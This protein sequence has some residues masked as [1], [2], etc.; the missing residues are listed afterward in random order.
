MRRTRA[1]C[2][3]TANAYRPRNPLDARRARHRHDLPGAFARAASVG[4]G[5]HPAGHRAD[6]SGRWS[7]GPRCAVG[8]EPRST[9]SASATFRPKRKSAGSRSPSS[10]WSRSPGP[11]RWRCRV[12]VLD[13][14]TSSLTRRDIERLFALIRRL[15][16]RGIAV[17]YISHFLEEVQEI[18]DRFAVLRDGESVGGG[19]TAGT[20][21]RPH[22]RADGRP[23]S[24]R[25][26]PP[27][28]PHERRRVRAGDVRFG[29]RRQT[30]FRE[31]ATPPR[32][33]GRHRRA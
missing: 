25:P 33:R 29:R 2:G 3:S 5:E 18:S 22:H 12:L 30:H 4:D 7:A 6:R 20:P 24:E 27:L 1:K 26:V 17:I 32:P 19:A 14:P 23:R 11:W 28:G 21:V 13:E 15:R 9:R 31:P 8:R 16:E 10:R